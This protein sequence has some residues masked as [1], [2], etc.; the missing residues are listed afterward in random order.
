MIFYLTN[1]IVLILKTS[2]IAHGR[3]Q[4]GCMELKNDENK[5]IFEFNFKFQMKDYRLSFV[6]KK[7]WIC[8]IVIIVA[9]IAF[10]FI[11]KSPP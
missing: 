7:G 6:T 10:S 9:K 1:S 4:G 2:F 11:E 3:A 5:L 8:A